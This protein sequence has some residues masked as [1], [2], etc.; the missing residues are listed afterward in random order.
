MDYSTLPGE[1]E[2]KEVTIL[3]TKF[4]SVVMFLHKAHPLQVEVRVQQLRL[5]QIFKLLMHMQGII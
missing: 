2:F 1:L 3:Q 4:F 5:K